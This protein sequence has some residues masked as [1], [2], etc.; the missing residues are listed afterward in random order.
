MSGIRNIPLLPPSANSRHGQIFIWSGTGLSAR[1]AR[2]MAIAIAIPMWLL[3]LALA[4]TGIKTD[5]A[6]FYTMG[7]LVEAHRPAALYDPRA[8]G[9]AQRSSVPNFD[10]TARLTCPSI[11]RRY[12]CSSRR[13]AGCPYRTAGL[14]WT[15]ER[16]RLPRRRVARMA[17]RARR[18]P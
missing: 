10:D 5:F 3:A 9:E 7:A 16:G 2:H 11:L 14:V 18:S 13:S 15:L 4:Q 12:P 8:F 1:A 6:V 17:R